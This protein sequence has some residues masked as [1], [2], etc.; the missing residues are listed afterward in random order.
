MGLLRDDDRSNL[1]LLLHREG[2]TLVVHRC[3]LF[4]RNQTFERA[5][6]EFRIE[7]GGE[8]N[9]DVVQAVVEGTCSQKL[10]LHER[11]ARLKAA[12]LS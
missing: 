10:R 2:P 8:S 5:T 4:G 1:G 9:R 7:G 12:T 6:K 11:I 3:N